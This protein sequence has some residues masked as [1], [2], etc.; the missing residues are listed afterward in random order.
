MVDW[1]KHLKYSIVKSIGVYIIILLVFAFWNFYGFL[2][3]FMLIFIQT[4]ILILIEPCCDVCM[5]ELWFFIHGYLISTVTIFV[6][7]I[8]RNGI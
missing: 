6:A 3:A 5:C 8:Y 7:T 2:C 4:H 1:I